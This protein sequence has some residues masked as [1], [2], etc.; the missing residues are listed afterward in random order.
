MKAFR[1]RSVELPVYDQM[2]FDSSYLDSLG[3]LAQ[4]QR[5]DVPRTD[6]EPRPVRSSLVM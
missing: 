3:P 2:A 5:P 4:P 6:V 1:D